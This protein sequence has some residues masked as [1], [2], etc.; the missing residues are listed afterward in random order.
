M[1]LMPGARIGAYEIISAIGA[2]GMG[3]VYRARDAR[4]GRDVAVKVLSASFAADTDRLK[5]FEQEARTAGALNHP[6][7]I[8]V[9]DLG[10]DPST[11]SGQAGAPF[12]VMELVEGETLRHRLASGPLP[13]RKAIDYATQIASGLAA[14]HD[15]G[16]VHRDLKPENIIVSPDGRLKILDFGL[17]KAFG[18][19]QAGAIA[20]PNDNAETGFLQGTSPGTVLGTVGYMAPEQVRGEPALDHRADLFALGAILYEMLTGR[21]AFVADSAV[22]TMSAILR[23]DPDLTSGGVTL[24]PGLARL[25]QRSLEK[26]PAERFQSARDLGFHLSALSSDS[27]HRSGALPAIGAHPARSRWAALGA[28]GAAGVVG[29]LALGWGFFRQTP[30]EPV[31]FETFTYSGSDDS[32]ST[33]PDGKTIAFSSSRNGRRQIW[34]KQIDGGG[35]TART[36]GPDDSSP[37]FSP[38]GASLLFL[39]VENGQS[40]LY[41]TAVLGGEERRLLSE[42]VFAD[43]PPDGTAIAVAF[44]SPER[45]AVVGIVQADGSN[46]RELHTVPDWQPWSLAWSPDGQSLL[47]VF[48][49]E[50]GTTGAQ[51]TLI[52][53]AGGELRVLHNQTAVDIGSNAAWTGSGEIVYATS[54]SGR[55]LR[56][57]ERGHRVVAHDIATDRVRTLFWTFAAPGVLDVVS[58]G[59]LAFDGISFSQNLRAVP[60]PRSDESPSTARLPS[61][62]GQA[63]EMW[64]TRGS[65]MD[66]QPAFSPDGNSVIFASNRSRNLDLWVLSRQDGSIKRLTDDASADWDPAYTPDGKSILWSSNR[67][68]NFEIWMA[69]TDGSGARQVSRDGVDAENPAMTPDGQW[70]LHWSSN[71]A[72]RGIWRVRPDGTD[73]SLLLR[74]AFN[75]PEISPD[76]RY[77][78]V[79]TAPEGEQRRIVVHRVEDG[80]AMPFTIRVDRNGT[81]EPN[82]GR[83]RWLPSGRAIA[84]V[85]AGL[86]G[87]TGIF[88]QDFVMGQDTTA[89]RRRLAGFAADSQSESFG[90]AP[91]GSVI[92][93]SIASVSSDV[94]LAHGIPRLLPPARRRP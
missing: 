36:Q 85:A 59:T 49:P 28:I 3:E 14:A 77:F 75:A 40:N 91:D 47:A 29:G 1:P 81:S 5:R 12:I 88:V 27:G 8:T 63:L 82:Y 52:P 16:I 54:T 10:V 71:P 72:K 60:L 57:A 79:S 92:V 78:A 65:S 53:V 90:V 39:R 86:D 70:V 43:W 89:T 76:G 35:E 58:P 66:R 25:V 15:R 19:A 41:R 7:L 46:R 69:A 38:D 24:P 93:I 83:L 34:L 42:V 61:G 2:G 94:L 6:N 62:S 9:F 22:E 80:A 48:V 26:N 84:F 74:G 32:P 68:G 13:I 73:A 55:V 87:R 20:P 56:F 11:G 23:A 37:R 51:V 30:V 31:R 45:H 21:R 44:M 17:A 33:S 18:S 64:L 67:G 50:V 4:L